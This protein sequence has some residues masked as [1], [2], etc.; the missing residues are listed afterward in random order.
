MCNDSCV[1]LNFSIVSDSRICTFIDGI[2]TQARSGRWL[3]CTQRLL[4]LF[5]SII[6]H[7]LLSRTS[8]L[9]PIFHFLSLSL[10][11]TGGRRRADG[12][13]VYPICYT[14]CTSHTSLDGLISRCQ[15]VYLPRP[16]RLYFW[17]IS[18]RI[19]TEC[20]R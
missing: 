15:S 17:S 5:L 20:L 19:Y 13:A 1:W 4:S 2:V 18:L 14:P 11:S 7:G 12:V 3:Q 6:V 8:L 16:G 10:R 9:L